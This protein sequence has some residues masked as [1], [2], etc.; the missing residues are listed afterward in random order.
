MNL[1]ELRKAVSDGTV[2]TVLLA[3]VDMQGRLQGKRLTASFFLD[4]VVEHDAE[5]CNYLLAVDVDMNTV[6]GYA[7]SSWEKGY[8]D[9]V[10]RPDLRTLRLVPW[11]P[12]TALVMADLLW[13]DG[14]PVVASPRQILR[15][16]LDRVAERGWRVDVGTELEFI[17][18]RDTYED[19]W[20]RGYRD[21]QPAN[22]YN[23]DYSLLGGARVEPLL[24]RIRNSMAA[25]D[26]SVEDAK[27]ECNL[28]QHEINFHYDD[29][30][31]TADNHSIYK[32]GAKEI[33][34]Q[35]GMSLTFMAKWDEREG[36]SCHIHCSLAHADGS[37][38]FAGDQALFESFVAGQLACLREL[39]LFLAPNI[40][41]YKRFQ[42]GSFAPTAIAWGKDNRTCPMRVVGHGPGLRVENRAPGADV[43]PYL[44]IAAT[45]AAG[46]HGIDQDLEL[47]AACEGN[48]YTSTGRPRL[49]T[50]LR[51]ARDLFAESRVA[52]DA[53]G[54]DV[55][56]H[57]LNYARVELDSFDAAVT[58][59]ERFRGFERL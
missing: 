25:A 22:L 39:T 18:F 9:F 3:L 47:E 45:I 28:G 52:R 58:D 48:A 33:A 6:D 16:Q 54:E 27:G 20:G 59:W 31:T 55:V 41:S 40:N 10:M 17:V 23:V 56:D 32:N 42:P 50:T 36:N 19:A 7:M 34:A 15:R 5:G 13:E 46:L 21:M 44:A 12:A 30:L 11:L 24:R 53:F 49:P 38:L 43:N 26:M 2:D 14:S 35:E 51:E 37:P 1:D 8:G 57:Y 4:Q 29:A